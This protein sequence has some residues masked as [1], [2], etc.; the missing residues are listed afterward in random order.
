MEDVLKQAL[1][2]VTLNQLLHVTTVKTF[3]PNHPEVNANLPKEA[4]SK[5]KH[6]FIILISTLFSIIFY[7][8]MNFYFFSQTN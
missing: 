2:S 7:T 4:H 3:W 1:F 8:E 6:D 5:S